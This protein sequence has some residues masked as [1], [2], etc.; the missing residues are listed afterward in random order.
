MKR[1]FFL[2]ICCL[3]IVLAG[4]STPKTPEAPQNT[5]LAAYREILEAAPAIQGEPAQLQDAAFGY[6]QNR[7]QFGDH[8]EL[9]ALHDLN[10][11]GTPELIALSEVNFRWTVVSVFTYADGKAALLSGGEHGSFE[12]VSTAGGAHTTYIC[13]ENHIH[14]VWSGS[15]PVG[16]QEEATVY[17]MS[18][19]G[20]TIVDC[21]ATEGLS[22]S[23]LAKA[24][25][26]ENI[27]ALM[28]TGK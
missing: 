5:A 10:G 3:A 1:S 13:A 24:N 25:T 2:L 6:E 21:S 7:E 9:F 26:P 23:E 11:D 28:P 8:Y 27:A 16:E 20:L 14:S 18:D 15:T 19:T 12:Q 4:C 17:A 22:F